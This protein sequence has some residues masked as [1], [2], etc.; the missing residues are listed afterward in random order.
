MRTDVPGSGW[1]QALVRQDDGRLVGAGGAGTDFAVVR[2]TA[3]GTLDPTF[4][5]GGIVTTDLGA[6]DGA[7]VVALGPGGTIVA[8]GE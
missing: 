5:T 7:R 4:G 3:G 6:E 2:Y 8:A 1:I